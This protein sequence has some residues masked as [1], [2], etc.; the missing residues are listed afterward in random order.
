MS[1]THQ[2]QLF[3]DVVQQG[4][5]TK[6]A[7]LHQMDNSAL[8]KQIKKLEA[9]LGV[10]LLNRSTRSFSLTSA[11]EEI[12]AQTSVLMETLDQ[13]QSIADAYQSEPKGILKIT[14][15][16]FFG[17]V[18]LQPVVARFMQRYPAVQINLTLDDRRAHLIADRYDLAFRVGKLVD[19][20]LIARKLANTNFALLASR[21]FIERHGMPHTPEALLALPAVIY[22]NGDLTLDQLVMSEQPHSEVMKRHRMRGNL[23]VSDIRTMMNAVEAGLG[24]G[25]V[26]L[27]HLE[28]PITDTGLVPLLTDYRLST[29]DTGI[30]AL[31]PHRKQTPLVTEF[32][33]HVAQYLG[34]PPFWEQHIPGYEQLYC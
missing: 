16:V 25:L 8:S 18:Y 2:L 4:S 20:N 15:P 29:L 6:A 22:S 27:F 31:Y 5:F 33:R 23:K 10:Q 21:D 3:H 12:L 14:A 30:Y 26:D 7:T 1:L 13:I 11:G 19:S 32:I 28:R 17:Q 24:Y 9:S 34:N